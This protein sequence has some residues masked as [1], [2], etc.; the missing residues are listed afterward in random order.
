MDN[1]LLAEIKERRA[2]LGLGLKRWK[3]GRD[4]LSGRTR[5]WALSDPDNRDGGV[6][7]RIARVVNYFLVIL[8]S[9]PTDI[10]GTP[11]NETPHFKF[12][13]SAPQD[14]DWLV[15]EVEK[16]DKILDW[17]AQGQP[18][19]S[20]ETMA[21]TALGVS[22]RYASAPS[23]P[24]DFNRCLLLVDEVPE[25]RDAFPRIRALSPKWAAIIDHWDE[26]KELFI[27]E[28]GWDWSNGLAAP[29]T[30]QRMKDLFAAASV[31]AVEEK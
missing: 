11:L 31:E 23:D 13:E 10:G 3:W 20:S 18:G 7:D 25:V 4:Y 15:A 8:S 22:R 30:F 26:L 14:V 17:L 1:K 29:K 28:V 16:R 19:V 6:G 12:I 24:S 21:F 2:G 9:S 5:H 27:G